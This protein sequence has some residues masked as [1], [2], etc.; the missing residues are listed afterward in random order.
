MD[1]PL[2]SCRVLWV[3]AEY[4]LAAV[5]ELRLELGLRD[6]G[7]LLCR[8]SGCPGAVHCADAPDSG[9]IAASLEF[10]DLS[11]ILSYL[12]PLTTERL[13]RDFRSWS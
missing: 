5:G 2:A 10:F 13:S 4:S 12:K 7:S 9:S 1:S 3:R 8:F 11:K 6:R